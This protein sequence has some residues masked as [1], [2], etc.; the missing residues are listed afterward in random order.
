MKCYF[1]SGVTICFLI[2]KIQIISNLTMVPNPGKRRRKQQGAFIVHTTGGLDLESLNCGLVC[3]V[4]A[5]I[6]NNSLSDLLSE[7]NPRAQALKSWRSSPIQWITPSLLISLQQ[8][9]MPGHHNWLSYASLIWKVQHTQ[10]QHI[11]SQTLKKLKP[12]VPDT[13]ARLSF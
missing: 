10:P 5:C 6:F 13:L 2:E 9:A 11:Q 7:F 3:Y 4:S 8:Q 12:R 1:Y